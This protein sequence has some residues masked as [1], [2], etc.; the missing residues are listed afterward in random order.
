MNNFSSNNYLY[1]FSY[2]I[3]R[4]ICFG[5][6]SVRSFT[7]AM[8]PWHQYGKKKKSKTKNICDVD[9]ADLQNALPNS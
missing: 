2:S 8:K 9:M 1:S 3:P 4:T 5:T 6:G 7:S